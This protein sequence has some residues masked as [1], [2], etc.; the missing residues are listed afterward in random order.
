VNLPEKHVGWRSAAASFRNHQLSIALL[1]LAGLAQSFSWIPGATILRRIFDQI[2]PSG[3]L[4]AHSAVPFWIAAAELMGLQMA[5][6]LLAWWIRT[7]ALLVSQDVLATL[8][9]YAI[10]H[11]YLLPREFHTQADAERL[12]LTLANE[13]SLIDNMNVAV[14]TQ[15]L[16]GACGALVLF[17]ILMRIE[18]LYAA[19]LAVLI[20]AL[21]VLNRA[22]QR[23]AWFRQENLRL[24]WLAYSRGVRFMIQAF[25]LTRSNSAEDFEISRQTRNVQQL[26]DTALELN[27]YDAAQQVLQGFLLMTCTLGAL[28]A[29]GWLAAGGHATRGDVMVFYAAAA[30]FAVQARSIVDSVPPIRRGLRAFGELDAL[31]HAT[32]REPYKGTQSVGAINNIRIEN[33]WFQYREDAPLLCGASLEIRRGEQIALIGANGSGKSTIVHLITGLYRPA[34]GGLF[35]NGQA[36]DAVDMLSLRDRMAVLP[37]NPFLFPGTV[38]D[39]LTYGIARCEDDSVWQ[40]L[41]WS[42]AADFV[43]EMPGQLEAAI[44]ELGILLSGGQRQK[45]A[46]ARALLRKPDFL[47]FDEP[48]NHLDEAAIT[49]LLHNIAL[50]PF[51]PAVLIISH[52]PVAV[53]HTSAAW[54]LEGGSLREAAA[55]GT[56]S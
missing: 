14:T 39:N 12:H 55:I 7:R 45:L 52:D 4:P 5:A 2:L 15:L 47:I 19:V 53:R 56:T 24:A 44:G 17:W 41:E 51:H 21:F 40:A 26:R 3:D 11:F 1:M 10:E 8:R 34:S 23:H 42:G 37:Q 29:G 13:T 49:I 43:N 46:L 28:F 48:T 6:L 35:V 30:L 9:T 36:Y 32:E 16:P 27:R 38:R 33:A 31:M 18:P 22:A 20:P 50:L 54:R 25:D